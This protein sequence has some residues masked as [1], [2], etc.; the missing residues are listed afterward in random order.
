MDLRVTQELNRIKIIK[1][2]IHT[3]MYNPPPRVF[4]PGTVLLLIEIYV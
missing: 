3:Y 1:S 4:I 2:D